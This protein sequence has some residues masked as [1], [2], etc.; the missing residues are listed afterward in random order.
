[1]IRDIHLTKITAERI[2]KLLNAHSQP[3]EINSIHNIIKRLEK[4][5]KRKR[6]LGT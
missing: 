3:I 2:E 4:E 1:M 6:Y 5:M